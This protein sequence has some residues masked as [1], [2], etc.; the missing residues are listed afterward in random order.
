MDRLSHWIGDARFEVPKKR[1]RWRKR[2]CYMWHKKHLSPSMRPWNSPTCSVVLTSF[3]QF[4]FWIVKPLFILRCSWKR[5]HDSWVFKCE[6]KK[7]IRTYS[8][9]GSKICL[10]LWFFYHIFE[11]TSFFFLIWLYIL[12]Y[13]VCLY[14]VKITENSDD[15]KRLA[16][17][18]LVPN[19]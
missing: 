15:V 9:H 14:N 12:I 18:N 5:I 11:I 1:W 16:N 3:D 6:G 4:A 13:F 8:S 10:I 17:M 19:K 7:K 2:T